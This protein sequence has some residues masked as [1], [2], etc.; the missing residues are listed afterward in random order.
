MAECLRFLVKPYKCVILKY[1]N[2]EMSTLMYEYCINL[3]S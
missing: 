3:L 2:G 1:T